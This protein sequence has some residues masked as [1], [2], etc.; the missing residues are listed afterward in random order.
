M[1]VLVNVECAFEPHCTRLLR[2]IC[3]QGANLSVEL[4]VL[5]WC[6]AGP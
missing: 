3:R 2:T 6:D 1:A 4:I 5:Q